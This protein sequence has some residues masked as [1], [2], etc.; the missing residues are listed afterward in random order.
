MNGAELMSENKIDFVMIWVD[1]NDPEWQK[2]KN[3]Y[4]PTFDGVDNTVVRYRDWDNLQYWFRGVEKYAPWVN[5]IHFV[6]WGHL[7]K[8]LDTGNPKLNIV[9]HRDFIPEKYLPTFNSNAIELNI[10]RIRGLSEQFVY[11]NDDMFITSPTTPEDFFRDGRP[12]D[13]YSLDCIYFAKN[14]AGFFNGNNM[15]IINSNFDKKECFK[16]DRAKWFSLK[17]GVKRVIKTAALDM[18]PWFP[19]IYYDHLCSNFLKITFE[20]AWERDGETLDMTCREKFRTK[21]N[22][23]QWVMKFWQLAK[24]IPVPRSVKEGHCFHIREKLSENDIRDISQGR[25]KRICIND[26]VETKDF[27]QEKLRVQQAFE[28]LLPEK[29]SFER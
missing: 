17:N 5:R 23:N 22:C 26:T 27:E 1:G 8:W 4:D 28:K 21:G 6:T 11:F 7:P 3:S 9:N 14:S 15:E 29:S 25:Y 13:T 16:R 12:L 2:E 24:G 10:H 18:W 19:G 20:E